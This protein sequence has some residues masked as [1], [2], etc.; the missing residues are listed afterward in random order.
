MLS[1]R[2][3]GSYGKS[4]FSF[5]EEFPYYSPVPRVAVPIYILTKSV[6]VFPFLHTLFS[7]CYL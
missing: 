2:I 3:T 4:I 5:F 7:V 1:I 6:G